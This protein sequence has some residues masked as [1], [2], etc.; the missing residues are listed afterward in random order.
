MRDFHVI[1]DVW[2][3]YFFLYSNMFSNMEVICLIAQVIRSFQSLKRFYRK[4]KDTDY[5]TDILCKAFA[6]GGVV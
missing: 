5:D 1:F 6:I 3:I 4:F 2:F